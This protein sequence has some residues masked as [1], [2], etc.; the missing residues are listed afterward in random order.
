MM[1]RRRNREQRLNC[2]NCWDNT[3]ENRRPKQFRILRRQSNR[4]IQNNKF[5]LYQCVLK[6]IFYLG[7]ETQRC[8]KKQKK[9]EK[10][11]CVIHNT[12]RIRI[13]AS[14][15]TMVYL[16][17]RNNII[18]KFDIERKRGNST[19]QKKTAY[20]FQPIF[21]NIFQFIPSFSLTFTNTYITN[22]PAPRTA[23]ATPTPK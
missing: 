2:P 19:N 8:Y 11:Y 20:N 14:A 4:I 16:Q 9:G 12:D 17:E 13:N 23:N 10:T 22:T 21:I 1:M 15:Q 18:T 5:D 6:Y 7:K 3:K